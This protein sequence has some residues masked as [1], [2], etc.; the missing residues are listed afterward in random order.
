M[1]KVHVPIHRIAGFAVATLAIFSTLTSTALAA[2]ITLVPTDLKP[3]DTYHLAFVSST[4]RNG[5]SANIAVYDA[6]VQSAANAAANG[7]GKLTWKA[8]AST[9]TVDA[10]VHI[11]VTGS[12]IY[13]VDDVRIANNLTDLFDN[14][15]LAPL[16]VTQKG[17]PANVSS[18]WTGSLTNGLRAPG[19]ALGQGAAVRKGLTGAG[20]G[21]Y[22]SF[23]DE[24]STLALAFY[25]VSNLLTVPVVALPEPSSLV[26]FVSGAVFLFGFGWRRERETAT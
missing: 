13:R 8:I 26:L 1:S 12:P 6:H 18:A 5:T 2:P 16:S 14:S 15:L 9:P 21:L 24:F 10:R 25:G 23:R 11:G 17:N 22:L 4:T 19:R 7:L 20:S 3:G